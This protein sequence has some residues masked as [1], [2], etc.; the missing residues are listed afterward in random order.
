MGDCLI[1]SLCRSPP[2]IPEVSVPEEP[3]LQFAS[4]VRI[5]IN[6]GFSVLREI[7]T[8]RD[9]KKFLCVCSPIF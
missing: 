1:I 6:Q 4:D 7:A 8:G 9:L 2:R 5:T 3:V